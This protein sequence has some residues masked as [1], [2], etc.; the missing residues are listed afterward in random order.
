MLKNLFQEPIIKILYSL[1]KQLLKEELMYKINF[2]IHI[3]ISYGGKEIKPI[4]FEI[5]VH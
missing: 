2:F 5:L 4:P 3:K 1:E